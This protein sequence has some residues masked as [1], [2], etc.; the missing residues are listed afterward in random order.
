MSRQPTPKMY[1]FR[2]EIKGYAQARNGLTPPE[3]KEKMPD[4]GYDFRD[5]FPDRKRTKRGK[6]SG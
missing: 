3:V 5:M 1:P 6:S 4:P 2:Q